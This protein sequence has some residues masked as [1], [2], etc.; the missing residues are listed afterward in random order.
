MDEVE[1]GLPGG[2]EGGGVDVVEVVVDCVPG[3]G[4][5]AGPPLRLMKR[6]PKPEFWA[7]AHTLSTSLLA[8]SSEK[9]S[10]WNFASSPPTMSKSMA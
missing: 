4:E 5:C 10:R 8:S 9:Y 7:M 3:G 6:S 1:Y 2:M